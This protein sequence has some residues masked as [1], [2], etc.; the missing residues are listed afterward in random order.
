MPA[1][2]ALPPIWTPVFALFVFALVFALGDIIA[3]KTKGLISSLIIGSVLFLIGFWTGLIPPTALNLTQLPALT[4]AI[5]IPLLLVHMG[6][7]IDLESLLKEWKTVLVSLV[8]LV[9][10]AIFSFTVSSWLFGKVYAL[11]ASGPIAGGIV[12]GV[13]TNDAA[14]AAG[15]PEI[16]GFAMLV[17][18][19]QMFIGM[20]VSSFMLKKEANRLLS[21]QNIGHLAG[22]ENVKKKSLK[23]FPTFPSYMNS[24]MGIVVRLAAVAWIALMIAN[25]TVIPGSKPVNYWLNPAIA[26]LLFGILFSEFG[27]LEKNS[28]T[29]ANAYGFVGGI[30]LFSILP[31][32]F[33]AISFQRFLQMLFPL[34][35]TLVVGAIAIAIFAVVCGKLLGYSPEMSIAI[36]MCALMGYPGTY[37][38]TN[39]VVNGLEGSAEIKEKIL[40][41]LLPKMLVAGFTTVTIASV[42]FAGVIGPMIFK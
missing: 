23:F 11:A 9:G 37:I 41:I 13:I 12:A 36:G 19:F 2:P 40:N 32:S 42:A 33:A 15:R 5:G 27:F 35:G 31:G 18:A 26:Y 28:L 39:E 16:G 14:V 22:D 7:I 17:V 30:A 25:L 24:P 4:G 3:D 8:G 6:T 29:K 20:P 1:A 38:V 34:V 10:L 21:A